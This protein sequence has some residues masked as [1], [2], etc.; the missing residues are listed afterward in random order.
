M[1][2]I[3]HF[4]CRRFATLGLNIGTV[5]AICDARLFPKFGQ[6]FQNARAVQFGFAF[7]ETR[8]VA[9]RGE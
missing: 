8:N 1:C 9:K 7:A 4:E 2:H 6:S 5:R 3:S